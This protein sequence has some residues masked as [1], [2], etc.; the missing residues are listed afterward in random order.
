V[1]DRAFLRCAFALC[2]LAGVASSA[3]AQSF[4]LNRFHAAERPDDAFGVRRLGAFGHLRFGANA[5]LDYANDPLVIKRNR[6]TTD[7]I[8]SI[9]DHQLTLK[10]DLSLALWDRLI[11]MA[12]FDAPL[13]MKGPSVPLGID[14]ADGG[15]FGDVTLGMRLRAIGD[16]DD[17]FG[18]G[19]QVIAVLPTADDLQAYTGEQSVALR[20]DVIAEIRTK[21]VRITA[22]VGAL[23]RE[24]V[25]FAAARIG[26]ELL[27]GLAVSVPLH[28]RFEAIGELRGSFDFERFGARTSSGLEWLA[29]GKANTTSGFWFGAGAGTGLTRGIGTPDVRVVGQLGYLTPLRKKEKAKEEPATPG[30]RDQ[31]GVPDA[32]DACPDKAE[33]RDG[34]GDEDGCPDLD[35]DSDGV[36]DV[37]DNCAGEAEDR[38]G[39][40][41]ED[42]C[43]DPDNDNDSVL[44]VD[45]A[46]PK[47]PGPPENRGCPRK[48]EVEGALFELEQI[49]FENNKDTILPQS[50]P[51]L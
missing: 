5:V 24:N 33:D 20:P 46:C 9:V 45:D 8:Q 32:S 2:A 18:L 17:V 43:P 39:Y 34:F 29:G 42:G 47:E 38:D 37:D 36:P 16:A 27:Y 49:Q 51:I 7:E 50:F 44:D 40:A 22:N 11:V 4:R 6:N 41:D 30:D 31:D 13:V 10:V 14:E 48:V 28:P 19:F 3:E 26:D 15:G 35:N 23:V 1:S 21:P 25:R 12:G